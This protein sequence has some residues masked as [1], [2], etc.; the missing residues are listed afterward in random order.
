[1][2]FSFLKYRCTVKDY[3][4]YEFYKLNSFGKNYFFTGGL[5]DRWYEKYNDPVLMDGLKNKE[6]N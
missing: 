3:M 5:A 4:I 6:K 1:M 2:A